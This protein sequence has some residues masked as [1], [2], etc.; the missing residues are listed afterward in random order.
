ME[1]RGGRKKFLWMVTFAAAFVCVSAVGQDAQHEPLRNR[2]FSLRHITAAQGSE[3]LHRLKLGE[4]ISQVPQSNALIVTAIP[5]DLVKASSLLET[6]DSNQMFVIDRLGPANMTNMPSLKE[7]GEKIGDVAFGTLTDPPSH[8]KKLPVILDV[9]DGNTVLIAPQGVSDRVINAIDQLRTAKKQT[10]ETKPEI[11]AKEAAPKEAAAKKVEEANMAAA[12]PAEA[13]AAGEEMLNKVVNQLLSEPNRQPAPPKEAKPKPQE[14]APTEAAPQKPA[15]EEEGVI[16]ARKE[17]PTEPTGPAPSTTAGIAEPTSIPHGQE[18]LQLQLP[19]TVDVV[20]L[21]DLVGK[22]LNINYL[23]DPTKVNGTV[24]LKLR[25]PINVSELYAVTES[26][27]KFKGFAMSRRDNL[28]TIVPAGEALNIDPTL[29]TNGEKVKPGDVVVTTVYN[30]KYI[31]AQSANLLLVNMRLGTSINPV[32]ES[33]TLIITD[34]AYRMDR[35]EK[36]LDMV[37]QP[38]PTRLFRFRQLKYTLASALV[39]KIQAVAQQLGGTMNVQVGVTAPPA[40]GPVRAPFR[41]PTPSPAAAPTGQPSI[42]LDYDERTN[43]ILMVGQEKEID[44]IEELVDTFDVPQQDLRTIKEYEIQYVDAR[45]VIDTLT[46]LGIISGAGVSTTGAAARGARIPSPVMPQPGQPAGAAVSPI[47]EP[48]IAILETTNSL[49]V[50]ATPEQHA[51]IVLVISYVDRTPAEVAIPYVAYPLE[52]Q[53]PSELKAVLM[54]LIE[55]TIKDEKGKVTQTISRGEDITVVADDKSFSVIV[56]AN[57]KNQEWVG[58]LIRQLDKKR[59]QVLID[60][61]LVEID[62]TDNFDYDMRIAASTQ[63]FSSPNTP[64]FQVP[65]VS[66]SGAGQHAREVGTG[67]IQGA[68]TL[69]GGQFFYSDK[70]IQALL[71]AVQLKNYGRVLA[72]PKIL[73]NDNEDG[74]ISTTQTTYRAQSTTQAPTTGPVITSTTYQSYDAKIELDIK[75]HISEGDLLLLEVKMTREDFAVTTD[76]A[77]PPNKTASNVESKVLVPDGATI[78]LGGMIK[79]NQGKGGT[80]VP[81]LGD[82]PIIGALFRGI[83]NSDSESKLYI[84]VKAYALRPTEGVKGLPE[85][86]AIS[87]ENRA[88]F[89]KAE[90]TFQTYNDIPGIKP[91]PMDPNRVLDEL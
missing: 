48:Q 83:H 64:P 66:S 15:A 5:I 21:L 84:F 13:N 25:G 73:V 87:N 60:V 82:L 81:I 58:S 9:Q 43:R 42:Y 91:K 26:V 32:A 24:T 31:S 86:E 74:K 8:L 12:A 33:N 75:P 27:L 6:V 40:R 45:E 36:L 30:L 78:I 44:V 16:E 41:P 54:E 61:T 79:L 88:A 71:Q 69:G 63:P 59:P 39:P 72:K 80:K 56:Y 55:K 46:T 11:G 19:E 28:V 1:N 70:S 51:A 29:K 35:I 85:A 90:R 18:E 52:F 17:Y 14:A 65:P 53:K 38:G 89:E 67:P 50:N 77:Q 34:Y 22:Y 20:A 4:T 10:A 49:L 57:R 23:Y 68:T 37:D 3:Y 62:R 7:L 2:V 47:E 76:P